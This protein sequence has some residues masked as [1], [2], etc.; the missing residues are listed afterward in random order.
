MNFVFRNETSLLI[1]I[2]KNYFFHYWVL[3]RNKM[4]FKKWAIMETK[5]VM[6][7]SLGKFNTLVIPL[8]PT[9]N[10]SCLI[11]NFF[12]VF[13]L[14]S[15]CRQHNRM[16]SNSTLDIVIGELTYFC[17]C[18]DVHIQSVISS[19][20]WVPFTPVI[21]NIHPLEPFCCLCGIFIF[22]WK[23]LIVNRRVS[24]TIYFLLGKL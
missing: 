5:I 24:G 10:S 8:W 20:W 19:Y 7:I 1:I 4:K 23:T 22:M 2:I 6:I 12:Y 15:L 21:S 16:E 17:G 14:V 11:I 18:L 13:L 3:I 9:S